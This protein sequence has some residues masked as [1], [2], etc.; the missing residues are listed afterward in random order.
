MEVQEDATLG[1]C[2]LNSEISE[3]SFGLQVEVVE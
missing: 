3:R 1:S 2:G